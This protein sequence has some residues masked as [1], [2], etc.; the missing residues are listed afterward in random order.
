MNDNGNR[1]VANNTADR[2]KHSNEES[3]YLDRNVN[4]NVLAD[5]NHDNEICNDFVIRHSN[6]EIIIS[7][8]II[9]SVTSPSNDC[10]VIEL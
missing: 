6:E 8:D 5:R 4:D 7:V 1:D 3:D 9:H 2:H 10:R